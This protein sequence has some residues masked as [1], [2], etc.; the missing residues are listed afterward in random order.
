MTKCSKV[1]GLF[2]QECK[3]I[4]F[5]ELN[6]CIKMFRVNIKT[7]EIGCITSKLLMRKADFK[8]SIKKLGEN[9]LKNRKIRTNRKYEEHDRKKI[10]E[11]KSKCKLS[12]SM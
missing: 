7:I 12:Q 10:Q 2:N 3:D 5:I 1:T 11:K 4:N 6:T 9:N 8:K